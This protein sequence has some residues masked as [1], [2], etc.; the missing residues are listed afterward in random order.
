M[1]IEGNNNKN[2][3]KLLI[4]QI[5]QIF[6]AFLRQF[7][8]KMEERKIAWAEGINN[9]NFHESFAVSSFCVFLKHFSCD[10]FFGEKLNSQKKYR[11]LL[12]KLVGNRKMVFYCFESIHLKLSKGGRLKQIELVIFPAERGKFLHFDGFSLD[13]SQNKI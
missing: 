7:P 1:D 2:S 10:F 11:Q 8:F 4:L 6:L 12:K 13:Q 5:I 3:G 9:V